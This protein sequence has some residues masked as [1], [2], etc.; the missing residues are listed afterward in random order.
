M[1][2]GPIA[3]W[4][5]ACNS[6]LNGSNCSVKPHRAAD[7][8]PW[9]SRWR[10]GDIIRRGLTDL[11]NSIIYSNAHPKRQPEPSMDH[12][13]RTKLEFTR[14]AAGFANSTATTDRQQ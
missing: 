6:S 9:P 2:S 13:Q 14:Q 12:L 11:A 1:D 3:I 10:A 5:V 7:Q 4:E 8:L